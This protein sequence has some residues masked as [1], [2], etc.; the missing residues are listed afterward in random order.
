MIEPYLGQ[1]VLADISGASGYDGPVEDRTYATGTIADIA[2][3]TGEITVT[4]DIGVM[5]LN[6]ITVSADQV[7]TNL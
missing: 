2:E 3:I 7:W 5:G 1:R 6:R 4:L